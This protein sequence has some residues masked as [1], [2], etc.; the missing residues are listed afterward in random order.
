M[1]EI[2]G[3]FVAAKASLLDFAVSKGRESRRG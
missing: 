2:D 1:V 3:A